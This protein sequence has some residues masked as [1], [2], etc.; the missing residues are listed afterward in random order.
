[1]EDKIKMKLIELI[2]TLYFQNNKFYIKI[3]CLKYLRS[4]YKI[5]VIEERASL[6][7]RKCHICFENGIPFD[8][9]LYQ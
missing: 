1:M 5:K 4:A 2:K 3:H 9:R 7:D 6:H 8:E